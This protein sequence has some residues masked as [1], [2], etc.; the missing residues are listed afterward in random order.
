MSASHVPVIEKILSEIG[1]QA[2]IEHFK[3][4]KIDEKIAV[5][6]NDDQLIRLGVATIGDRARFRQ[7]CRQHGSDS[8]VPQVEA[9][10][11]QG[12]SSAQRSR[13]YRERALL[14]NSRSSRRSQ[15]QPTNA[16][17]KKEKKRTW[18]ATFVCLADR[19]AVKV[20]T[21]SEK[22]ILQKAG[23]GIKRIKFEADYDEKA[24]L[25]TI[26]SSEVN[27][28]TGQTIGFP[29]LKECGGFELMNCI[30][31]CRNL[32][33]LDCSWSVKSLKANIGGQS[34]IYL[35]PI[36]KDL[37]TQ[38]LTEETPCEIKEKCNVCGQDVLVRN[39]RTHVYMCAEAEIIRS[40]SE[41][42][43]EL[44]SS[45][46]VNPRPQPPEGSSSSGNPGTSLA[47][48]SE[49]SE[50]QNSD[51]QDVAEE[52]VESLISEIVEYCKSQE[53]VDPV[54]IL[55]YYQRKF[56][57]GRELEIANPDEICEGATSYILVD[58]GNILTTSFDE[59]KEISNL[60]LTLQ[61]NFYGECAEDYGGPRKEF[62]RLVLNAIK[63]KYF[64]NGLKSHIS[65]DYEV[66]GTIMGLSIL[67]NGKIPTFLSD[68]VLDELFGSQDPQ[69][70]IKHMREGLSKLGLVQIVQQLPIMKNLFHHKEEVLTVKRLINLFKP[71][72]SEEGSNNRILEKSIYA[73]F[74]KYIRE[75]ASGRRGRLSLSNI[76][77]FG[78]CADQEPILGFCLHPTLKFFEV[79]T[80]FIPTANTCTNCI[81]LP[82]PTVNIPLPGSEELFNLF[83]Y[84][85]MNTYF[86]NM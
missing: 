11:G 31:N 78:T 86:G 12:S 14:F 79:T 32:S 41:S 34:R 3:A 27:S 22:Q 63:S 15:S 52:S 53:V 6:L 17:K 71:T 69:P 51:V 24:V 25:E 49:H 8:A 58:R 50:I 77:E 72:F 80:T 21:S 35:R 54:E 81:N 59:I 60:R 38:S 20:P 55:R 13:A 33:T 47:T 43:E 45:F 85:F 62:F 23:L 36:Q 56:V 19:L 16:A 4:E 9:R 44:P 73:V 37:C 84:A 82:R 57:L 39:L 30:A 2:V 48:D 10:E 1:L 74:L 40:D 46:Q 70:C 61:V 26:T 42:E 68:E 18:T 67:Q 65:E 75:V 28:E 76:L 83:D 66:V 64:N 7:L 5:T 29:K